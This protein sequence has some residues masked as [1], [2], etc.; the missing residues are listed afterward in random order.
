MIRVENLVKSY[1]G[2]SAPVL[3]GITLS[4]AR[5]DVLWVSGPSGS[6]KSTLLNVLG[7]LTTA[8]S[9][10]YLVDGVEMLFA[11]K[12]ARM[13]ARCELLSTIFQ[14]GNLFAHLT[15]LD[16]VLVGMP[17]GGATDAMAHLDAV[18]L[19]G[20]AQQLAGLLS[21]GEQERVAI[22]RA[23]ARRTPVL[24]ADEPVAGLDADNAATVMA[25]LVGAAN[26]GAAV[27]VVSHDER[28]AHV[29]TSH[30]RLDRAA[31]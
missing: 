6:G 10:Q 1:A 19:G 5:G 15:A 22:A 31:S 2:A 9:G 20:K 28:R 24:L 25:L 11:S 4:V 3:S 30:L 7:L 18:G 29:A 27:V 26:Q 13:K 21:G 16:N 23:M 14:R 12:S 8:D 17:T